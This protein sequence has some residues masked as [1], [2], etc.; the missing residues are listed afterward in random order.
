[1]RKIHIAIGAVALGCFAGVGLAQVGPG[2]P[3][4]P[5]V[6]DDGV[7]TTPSFPLPFTSYASPEARAA[8]V[9]MLR[10]PLAVSMNLAK[11]RALTDEATKPRLAAVAELYPYVATP[12]VISGVPVIS[13]EPKAGIPAEHRNKVL[14]ELHGGAFIVGGGGPGG[15]IE[16][17]PVAGAARMRVI[18]VDYRLAPENR[19]PAGSEDVAKVYTTL[20]KSYK[21]ENIGIFGC[22]AGG[23]LTAQAVAWLIDKKIPVPGAIGIF[24]AST[25]R[26]GEGDSAQLWPLMGSVIRV[27]PKAQL[28]PDKF[29]PGDIYFSTTNPH[30]P[31][32]V[33]SASSEIMRRFPPV[34]LLTG[35]RAPDMSSAA[36]SKIEFQEL[37][38]KAD[39]ILF[40]GMDHGFFSDAT[41][42]E[43]RRAYRIMAKFFEDNLGHRV[44]A[45]AN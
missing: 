36:M 27:T 39:L 11:M 30:D 7:M 12:S 34:L 17:V 43:S 8:F 32:A 19:F 18:A 2:L 38:V 28:D 4:I 44:G 14:I 25:H 1:M 31:L 22:S 13:Y 26:A 45:P 23:A 15:A 10:H 42:P 24:C 41:L 35:T 40:D 20:L 37:G 6:T 16:S 21:P 3:P 5:P 29:G 33:P 9:Q